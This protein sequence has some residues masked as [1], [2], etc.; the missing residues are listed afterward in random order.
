MISL[1]ARKLR[2]VG[3]IRHFQ[4]FSGVLPYITSRTYSADSEGKV[5]EATQGKYFII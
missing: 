2:S 5:A 1:Q 4:A 3:T